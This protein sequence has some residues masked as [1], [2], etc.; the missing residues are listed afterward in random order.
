MTSL[1]EEKNSG[2]KL[3]KEFKSDQLWVEAPTL[4]TTCFSAFMNDT[5]LKFPTKIA[6]S[7]S[8]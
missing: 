5:I 3:D 8:F 4:C 7:S 2:R 6:T 1:M